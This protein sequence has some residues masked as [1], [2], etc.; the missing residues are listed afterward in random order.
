M[1]FH[2]ITFL[3]FTIEIP[4]LGKVETRDITIGAITFFIFVVFISIVIIKLKKR[5]LRRIQLAAK[6]YSTILGSDEE[7]VSK[8]YER[9]YRGNIES[10]IYFLDK[11]I[12]LRPEKE[13]RYIIRGNLKFKTGDYEGAL[14]DFSR[15]ISLNPKNAS[16]HYQRGLANKSLRLETESQIDFDTAKELGYIFPVQIKEESD[17]N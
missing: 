15:T 16:A 3:L 9:L 17:I 7:C 14:L 12:K 8:S 11:A 4:F 1:T 5:K 10:A 6:P 13:D 2:F